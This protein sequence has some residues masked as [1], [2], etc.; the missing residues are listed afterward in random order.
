MRIAEIVYASVK[1][2]TDI[3][4]K[5][6]KLSDLKTPLVTGET[7]RDHETRSATRNDQ[8]DNRTMYGVGL[9][10]AASLKSVQ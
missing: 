1:L 6:E 3:K 4:G 5:L 10:T 8:P 2:V 9:S 7:N